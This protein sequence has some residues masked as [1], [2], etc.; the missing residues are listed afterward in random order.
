[1]VNLLRKRGGQFTPEKNQNATCLK[2][3]NL[4][5]NQVVNLT[6]FSSDVRNIKVDFARK[7]D[8]QK[9]LTTSEVYV[10]LIEKQGKGIPETEQSFLYFVDQWRVIEYM[11]GHKNGKYKIQNFEI[12]KQDLVILNYSGMLIKINGVDLPTDQLFGWATRYINSKHKEIKETQA[13][14]ALEYDFCGRFCGVVF[15]KDKNIKEKLYSPFIS[16]EEEIAAEM[17]EPKDFWQLVNNK[18]LV[19][20]PHDKLK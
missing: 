10:K 1:V 19:W 4:P 3:V 2:V 5:R 16:L 15:P 8:M 17:F 12:F 13:K 6:G 7:A 20:N 11:I 14:D 18:E 9:A